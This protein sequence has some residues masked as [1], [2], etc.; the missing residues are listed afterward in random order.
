MAVYSPSTSLAWATGF[1]TGL[2]YCSYRH[3]SILH[4]AVQDRLR[5]SVDLD[6]LGGIEELTQFKN[7]QATKLQFLLACPLIGYFRE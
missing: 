6:N 4:N 1:K 2:T 5:D 3:V 7:Y